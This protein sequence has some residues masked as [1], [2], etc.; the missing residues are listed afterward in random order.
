M[1]EAEFETE[2]CVRGY[3]IYQ[4][5]WSPV[6]GE[7]L[8]VNCEQEEGNA[9]DRY[10]VAIKIGRDTV[11]HVPRCISTLCSLF[12][13]RGGTIFCVVTGRR[14]YSRDL[15]QGGMEI[16]CK[17]RF[18]GGGKE[19]KKV[20]SYI[21]KPVNHLPSSRDD[22]IQQSLSIVKHSSSQQKGLMIHQ[23]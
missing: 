16:P 3:H 9:Q 2:S 12:I 13:R 11:G 4:E 22:R 5:H 20:R 21:T 10:A 18:V 23:I 6:I 19:I 17:Y 15:P 8:I 1:A 14:R 7:R